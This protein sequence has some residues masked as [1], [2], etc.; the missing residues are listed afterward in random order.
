L[1]T[2][3]VGPGLVLWGSTLLVP[4]SSIGG[5]GK[6]SGGGDSLG[7]RG[8]FK[9]HDHQQTQGKKSLDGEEGVI[10]EVGAKK[11]VRGEAWAMGTGGG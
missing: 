10:G 5:Q 6:F 3:K 9:G 8:S 4:L 2:L 7:K 11:W 1:K